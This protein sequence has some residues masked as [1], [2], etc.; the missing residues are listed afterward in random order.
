MKPN[1]FFAAIGLFLFAIYPIFGQN[2]WTEVSPS[3]QRRIEA[4]SVVYDDKMYVFH[5]YLPGFRVSHDSE[6]YD[7]QTDTW[8]ALAP[9]PTGP[10]TGMTH[11]GFI[12]VD[13]EVWLT[14]GKSEFA[15]TLTNKVWIY[16]FANDSWREGSPLPRSIASA[17]LIKLGRKLYLF[18]GGTHPEGTPPRQNNL[19][20]LLDKH[21]VYDLEKPE[22]GWQDLRAPLPQGFGRIHQSVAL[23][24]GKFYVIGGQDGHDCGSLDKS[25]VHV[26][27]PYLDNWERL[28]D[29]PVN[30]SHMEPGTSVVDGKIIVF[31]GEIDNVPTGILWQYDPATNQWSQID[32]LLNNNGT[33][34]GRLAAS[35]RVIGDTLVVS[36]GS[37]SSRT[38]VR[39]FARNRQFKLG[40]NP[41]KLR[42]YA[43]VEDSALTRSAWLWTTDG[44][45]TFNFDTGNLPAWIQV[46]TDT[47]DQIDESGLEIKLQFD[48]SQV[49]AGTYRHTVFASAPDYE[50]AQMEIELVVLNA[51]A[52][53]PPDFPKNLSAKAFSPSKVD[54]YWIGT[55]ADSQKVEIQRREEGQSNFVKVAEVADSLSYYQDSLLTPHTRYDYRVRKLGSNVNSAYSPVTFALTP[56]LPQVG[57]ILLHDSENDQVI[58]ALSNRIA[59]E[60]DTLASEEFT[61]SVERPDSAGFGSVLIRLEGPV[62]AERVES[63][64]PFTLFGEVNSQ[65]FRGRVFPAGD[66]SLEVIPYSNPKAQGDP[67]DTTRIRFFLTRA[68]AMRI[69]EVVLIDAEND[70]EL[71]TIQ[72]GQ[73]IKIDTLGT[74]LLSLVAQPDSNAVGSV[75][76]RLSGAQSLNRIENSAPFSLYGD[77]RDDFAGQ[78]M[79]TG[80]YEL[81]I[82]PYT[83][84]WAQGTGGEPFVLHF[85]LTES[86]R[87]KEIVLVDASLDQDLQTLEDQSVINIDQVGNRLSIRAEVSSTQSVSFSLIDSTGSLVHQQIENVAPYSLFGENTSGGYNPWLPVPSPG[88]YTLTTIPYAQRGLRGEQGEPYMLA[89]EIA[90]TIQTD[91]LPAEQNINTSMKLYPNPA[92]GQIFLRVPKIQ[93]SS[94]IIEITNPQGEIKYRQAHNSLSPDRILSLNLDDLSLKEGTYIIKIQDQKKNTFIRRVI[95]F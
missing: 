79:P 14:G 89:F 84:D 95:K 92:H 36:H 16:N 65:D 76:F 12:I 70:Q 11:N 13:D 21:Y 38:Y 73:T 51:R 35:A 39:P 85:T 74:S 24:Q 55:P 47:V 63:F 32:Q 9:L 67:G 91:S 83:L 69:T 7:P 17:N 15:N 50:A 34:Q 59:V 87:V 93:T 80:D 6:V 25:W 64:G 82:I 57:E 49:T 56:P 26:Y 45:T 29:L 60:M 3:L 53:L 41:Q 1:P 20:V 28:A 58:T 8:T 71:F 86:P 43:H 94:F 78:A 2:N 88:R 18:G 52:D 37:F 62:S 19:C 77:F 40:F 54:L 81:K 22:A 23:W 44:K 27:D 46:S 72:D 66:Y 5:G 10:R 68:S 30:L 4:S 75:A 61:I 33:P 90:D 31:G 48:P 42:V